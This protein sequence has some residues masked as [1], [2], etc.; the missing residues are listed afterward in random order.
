MTSKV[1]ST[2]FAMALLPRRA[3]LA[4][5]QAKR[6]AV[7]RG[8]IGAIRAHERPRPQLRQL[9]P[10]VPAHRH[11][12]RADRARTPTGSSPAASS[13]GSAA[14]RCSPCRAEGEPAVRRTAPLRDHRAALDYVL[15][16]LVSPEARRPRP[17]LAGRHPRRR[18]PRRARRR[19]V[20]ALGADRRRGARP[21]RGLHRPRA[22]AQPGEPQ[23]DPRGARASS[24]RACRRS[25]SSTPRSTRRCRADVV[26]LRDPLPAL[27]AAT[28]CAATASTARR[29]ATSPTATASSPAARTRSTNIITLHL[30][31]GCSA[32]AIR[33][34]RLA[35]HLDG[36]H[37]ARGAR[38]GHALRRPRPARSS[39]SCTTRR[40]CRFDEVD[41]AAQQA[42]GPARHLGA[43]QRHARAARRGARAPGPPGAARDRHLL[44]AGEKYIGA[45]LA[46]MSGADAI[47][48]AGGIGE[49]SPEIRAP[50]LRRTSTSS[51][52]RSTRRATRRWSAGRRAR[53]APTARASR[54]ASSRPTRSC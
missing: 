42:V 33:G 38:H 49:N 16:W 5:R 41:D 31:N 28:R 15:R 29:T 7:H 52:S 47:V 6:Q 17:R 50:D 27:R 53:S 19:E 34:G 40:G 14:R 12:P 20:H 1:R 48:F 39:S 11:R 51:G 35:G 25:P 36:P 43:D 22:A 44:P 3:R 8:I 2:P 21:D 9:L 37:P 30:G 13:S 10:Q 18:A 32:C 24:A 45:Y 26:P 46:Q 4:A 23:G 54:P